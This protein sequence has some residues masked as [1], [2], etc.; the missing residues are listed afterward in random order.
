VRRLPVAASVVPSSAI[1]VTLMEALGTSETSLLTR[2]TW[3]NIPEDTI[4]QTNPVYTTARL[5]NIIHQPMPWSSYWYLSL[6][7]SYQYP[8]SVLLLST[9]AIS[10]SFIVLITKQ[11]KLRGP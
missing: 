7:L 4:L 1:L 5:S 10:S 8:T 2:A 11:N 9:G 3:R 6:W